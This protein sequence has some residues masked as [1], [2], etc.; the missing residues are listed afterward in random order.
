MKKKYLQITFACI[1]WAIW[2][3]AALCWM[4][5]KWTSGIDCLLILA[6]LVLSAG[7]ICLITPPE[8]PRFLNKLTKEE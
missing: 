6:I 8:I 7:A 3:T 2:S 1:M 5:Y 4:C